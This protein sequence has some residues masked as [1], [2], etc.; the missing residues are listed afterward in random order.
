MLEAQDA[1]I[2]LAQELWAAAAEEQDQ[3]REVDPWEESLRD[4]KGAICDIG[5]G[6]LQERAFSIDLLEQRLGMAKD[7]HKN[8]DMKRLGECMRV[9]GWKGPRVL[10]VGERQGRGYWRDVPAI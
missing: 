1:S 6:K 2:V 3:R 8:Q 4:Y 5:E 10:R 9:L 7:R